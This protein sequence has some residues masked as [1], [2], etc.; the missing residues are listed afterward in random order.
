MDALNVPEAERAQPRRV[1]NAGRLADVIE[2]VRASVTEV[3]R[4]RHGPDSERV[5]DEQEDPARA[6]IGGLHARPGAG[7]FAV[8]HSPPPAASTPLR[9]ELLDLLFHL[10][11]PLLAEVALQQVALAEL[12]ATGAGVKVE[13]VI[14]L[15]A[16]VLRDDDLDDVAF[17]VELGCERGHGWNAPVERDRRG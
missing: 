4:V 2:G 9:D 13:L 11:D 14:V 17:G 5:E 16:V 12:P 15:A 6:A 1:R 3:R 8:D 7:E 10:I